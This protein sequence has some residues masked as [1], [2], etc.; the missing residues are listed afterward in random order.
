MLPKTELLSHVA[1]LYNIM[2]DVES[3]VHIIIG[4][5]NKHFFSIIFK[6]EFNV[7]TNTCVY[8][9]ISINSMHLLYIKNDHILVILPWKLQAIH[10]QCAHITRY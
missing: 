7:H 2:L 8:I 10:V 6:V 4:I 5:S 1:F 9:H 3:Y